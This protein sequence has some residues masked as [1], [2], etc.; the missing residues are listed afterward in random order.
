MAA[1]YK[2]SRPLASYPRRVFLE[3]NE[4]FDPIPKRLCARCRL[5]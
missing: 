3:C 4:D 5:G 1:S 2:L